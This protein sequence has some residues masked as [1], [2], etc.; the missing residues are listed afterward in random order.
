[1]KNTSISYKYTDATN[2]KTDHTVIF[3]GSA[4]DTDLIHLFQSLDDGD[5]FIPSQ[6]GLLDIQFVLQTHDVKDNRDSEGEYNPFGPEG[7]DHVWHSI[8]RENVEK[9]NLDATEA[10]SIQEFV[11]AV[12]SSAHNWDVDAAINR[13]K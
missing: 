9:T 1:M 4:T 3:S 6:V 11:R 2:Y 10:R 7:S 8:L 13:L 5:G 12:M